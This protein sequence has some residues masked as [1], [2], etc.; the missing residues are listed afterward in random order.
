MGTTLPLFEPEPAAEGAGQPEPGRP[1]REQAGRA[2]RD[3][4]AVRDVRATRDAGATRHAREAGDRHL[5]AA[6]KL[7]RA[8]RRLPDRSPEQTR[9]GLAICAHL[10]ALLA[11]ESS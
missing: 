8:I 4:R 2:S 7:S 6:R 9:A 3:G 11:A 5:R 1:P 10:K